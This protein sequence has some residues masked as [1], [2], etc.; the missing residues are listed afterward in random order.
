V[1]EVPG[2]RWEIALDLL[3]QGGPMFL[4]EGP[5][6]VGVQRHSGWPGADGKIHVG[7]YTAHEPGFVTLE[8]A[9]AD[10]GSGLRTLQRALGA[11]PRLGALLSEYGVVYE[12]LYDYGQGAVLI[13]R[14][15]DDGD[16]TLI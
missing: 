10:V 14:A 2:P 8:M 4:L 11:D 13:G 15:T 3:R 12:Y 6:L 1:D 9:R 5:V 16:V 7:I